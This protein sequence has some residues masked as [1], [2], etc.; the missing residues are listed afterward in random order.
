MPYVIT[1]PCQND[2]ACVEVCPVGCIH[3]TP[4]APQ[5]YIDPEI[6]IECEQCPV[7]CPFE[8]IFI[9]Y[10]LP[11]QWK[12]YEEINARFFRKNKTPLG[13][14]PLETAWQMVRLAQDYAAQASM[15]VSVAVVDA[16]GSPIAVSRMDGARQQ[17]VELAIN[18]AFTA[19]NFH[20]PTQ[21]L[22][23]DGRQ[24]WFRSLV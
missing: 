4:D 15:A 19:M 7:V 21:E 13:P 3:T 16:A 8:A 14:V 24:V 2:G 18:K 9:H 10:E 20:L 1:E 6:C 11:E 23:A 22:V 17:T 5:H 12:P